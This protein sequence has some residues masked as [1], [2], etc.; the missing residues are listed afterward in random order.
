[1][2]KTSGLGSV[3]DFCRVAVFYPCNLLQSG[4]PKERT[5]TR[6][7]TRYDSR[8]LYDSRESRYV[9]LLEIADWVRDGQEIEVIDKTSGESLTAQTLTQIILEEG[10]NGRGRLSSELLHDLVRAS[11]ERIS[12]GVSQVQ[13]GLNRVVRASFDRL[14]PVKEAREEMSRLRARLDDFETTLAEIERA[15]QSSTTEKE[16]DEDDRRSTSSSEA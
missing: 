15:R 5:L 7:I 13:K 1:M 6:T 10:K 8:K 11:G 9:S 3:G 2:S 12:I 4:I 14:T 16:S